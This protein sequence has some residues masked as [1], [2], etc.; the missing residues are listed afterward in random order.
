MREKAREIFFDINTPFR[1]IVDTL[2][3]SK[4]R[5][6]SVFVDMYGKKLYSDTITNLEDAYVTVYGATKEEL[7]EKS[8]KR[9]EEIKSE[10]EAIRRRVEANLPEL[11]ERA[12][13]LTFPAK[14]EQLEREL[15]GIFSISPLEVELIVDVMEALATGVSMKEIRQFL[16]NHPSANIFAVRRTVLNYSKFGPSFFVKT[17][18]ELIK[19]KQMKVLWE[20]REENKQLEKAY[21]AT[22]NGPIR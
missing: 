4:K 22:E 5:G 20:I 2:L 12:K 9:D 17:T 1:E 16:D 15:L 13:E 21:E 19:P 11:L 18:K 10:W 3:E 8:K 7:M 14:Q 6:Q